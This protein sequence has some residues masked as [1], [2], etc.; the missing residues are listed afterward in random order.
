MAIC[1]RH[2]LAILL[3]LILAEQLE[4]PI[5][6]DDQLVQSDPERL[7]WFRKQLAESAS[8]TQILVL[9]CR[10]ADYRSPD[11]CDAANLIDVAARVRLNAAPHPDDAIAARK[12]A[13]G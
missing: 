5:V 8:K 12:A 13:N 3:R 6:L 11:G 4:H 1:T 10:S 7:A 9:S 2:Q